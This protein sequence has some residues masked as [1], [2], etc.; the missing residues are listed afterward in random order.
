M[1]DIV[2][3]DMFCGAGGESTGLSQACGDLGLK[4]RL[5]AI[6]HWELAIET[7]AANHPAAE[8]FCESVETLKPSRCGAKRLALLWAS[9]ECTHHSV[10][11]GGRPCDDQSR[12]TAWHILKWAQELYIERIIVENVPEFVHWGPLG[13][14]GRPMVSK[15]GDAFRA[16]L[17]ALR[18]LGYTVDWRLLTAADYGDPTTRKRLFVQ[19][20]RTGKRIVWPQPT[21]TPEPDMFATSRWRSA[22]ECIDWELKG[23]SIFDRSR[24]LCP[25]TIARIAHGL[26][27]FG[28][29]A[30][31]PFLVKLY[32]T[33]KT[34]SVDAPMPTVTSGGGHLGLVESFILPQHA[35]Y[36][37]DAPRVHS[38]DRPLSTITTDGG[39]ALVQPFIVPYYSA[40]GAVSI[41]EPMD[42][43]TTKA[44]FGLAVP[45]GVDILYRMFEP[46]E[47]A[48]AQGFPVDYRFCGNKGDV[49]KQIGNAVP[50]NLAR[51]LCKAALTA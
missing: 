39:S 43:V 10:A 6:N 36:P 3:V 9:P 15:R 4:L 30:A 38:I 24:P 51:A 14:N 35:G 8:H 19:A 25:K 32:G 41:E 21:H 29:R 48:A 20:A 17:A 1:K 27:K 5:S 37:G 23:K 11:R 40:S 22:R 34:G 46:R 45:E 26:R 49:T 33:S 16:W 42:T 12:A 50:V 47:L 18:A 31:D 2:A 28:G 7:H 13:A 44:K